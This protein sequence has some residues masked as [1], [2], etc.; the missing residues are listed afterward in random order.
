MD[1]TVG[2]IDDESG[3]DGHNETGDELGSDNLRDVG[4]TLWDG[5]SGICAGLSS[6]SSGSAGMGMGNV[7]GVA[8][9][10]GVSSS[11][12]IGLYASETRSSPAGDSMPERSHPGSPVLRPFW[13]ILC[14][15]E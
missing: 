7:I 11:V 3:R 1:G 10:S 5:G 13:T 8:V 14:Q 12:G 6:C 2:A 15:G 9:T 4:D